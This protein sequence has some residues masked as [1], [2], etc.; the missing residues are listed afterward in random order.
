[1]EKVPLMIMSS[2]LV[3]CLR[4]K[5]DIRRKDGK[6]DFKDE[7]HEDGKHFGNFQAFKPRDEPFF[8]VG[9]GY[10]P[11]SNRTAPMRSWGNKPIK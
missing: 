5:Q 7:E 4:E 1:M 9:L 8:A 10:P 2:T 6:G 11:N 3:P